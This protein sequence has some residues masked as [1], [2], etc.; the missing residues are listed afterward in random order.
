MSKWNQ[1]TKVDTAKVT[2]P[3]MMATHF[4][5]SSWVAQKR[6]WTGPVGK[7]TLQ[8]SNLYR[9][10]HLYRICRVSMEYCVHLAMMMLMRVYGLCMLMYFLDA[11]SHSSDS[12]CHGC[13]QP[14]DAMQSS[15]LAIAILRQLRPMSSKTFQ[16][17]TIFGSNMFQTSTSFGSSAVKPLLFFMSA[18]HLRSIPR[19]QMYQKEPDFHG[20]INFHGFIII[21]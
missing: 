8:P 16:D 19:F 1:K 12:T 20:C 13:H 4:F 15:P 9:I 11:S 14:S 2:A 17:I 21:S 6:S 3:E 10:Q 7:N 5:L 18:S